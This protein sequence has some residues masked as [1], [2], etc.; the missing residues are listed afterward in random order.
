MDTWFNTYGKIPTDSKFWNGAQDEFINESGI[1]SGYRTVLGEQFFIPLQKYQTPVYS[2]IVSSP[3]MAGQQFEEKAVKLGRG[4]RFNPKQTAE[5]NFKFYD[6]DGV[7]KTYKTNVLGRRSITIPSDLFSMEM[8]VKGSDVARLNDYI[9][10]N[11]M[12]GYEQD[13][14]SMCEKKLVSS[15]NSE[16]EIDFTLSGKEVIQQINNYAVKMRGHTEHFN[17]LD[18]E[19]N[20][21]L[22]TSSTEGIICFIDENT[23]NNMISDY[24]VLPSPDKVVNNVTFI[25]MPDGLP[26]PLTTQEWE[27]GPN[28][29]GDETTYVWDE[30]PIAIDKQK[31][32]AIIMDKRKMFYKPILRSY[33]IG[34]ATNSAGDFTNAHLVYRACC[35]V[36][37]WYNAIRLNQKTE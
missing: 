14:E 8:F 27:Q 13:V 35:D 1:V 22:V 34:M 11:M 33:K 12:Q 2:Q 20:K 10:E 4:Y 31:P 15:I 26:Q 32:T 25:P 21:N 3:I 19:T 28:Y 23:Y 7:T 29:P 30:K 9:Y 17:E 18:E 5:D 16:Q 6:T 36:R 24:A 37:P